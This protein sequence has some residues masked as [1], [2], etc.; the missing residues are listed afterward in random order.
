MK[1]TKYALSHSG[2]HAFLASFKRPI[3]T[4]NRA[5]N[6][7]L[8]RSLINGRNKRRRVL[9]CMENGNTSNTIMTWFKT[10]NDVLEQRISCVKRVTKE[11]NVQ[12]EINL[13]GTGLCSAKT[14][15]PFLN[16]MLDVCK[17]VLSC[18]FVFS[19]WRPMDCS[20]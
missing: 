11:T 18:D 14:P 19:N 17:L 20:M 6:H 10:N 9:C 12:V 4:P 5:F 2:T 3:A 7:H 13:D 15:I 8:S 1:Q 16:H